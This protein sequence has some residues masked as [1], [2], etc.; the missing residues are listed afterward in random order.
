[1]P[2]PLALLLALAAAPPPCD[3]GAL[4]VLPL[5]AVAVARAE[6]L[7][8]EE[9][10]RRALAA[11]ACVQPAE[12]TRARL[13]ARD[14]EPLAAC[15][16]RACAPGALEALGA[17]W[18][19]RGTLLGVGGERTLALSLLGREGEAARRTVALGGLPGALEEGAR[20][21]WRTRRG[22]TVA[23]APSAWPLVT[24]A[25]GGVALAAGAGLGLAARQTEARLS[26]A[27]GCTG[28][29]E[30]VRA[31]L[32]AGLAEGR[33]QARAAN[34]LLGAGALLGAGGGLWLAWE[35]P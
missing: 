10:L 22:A 20:E 31:C 11:V 16:E 19:L 6:A 4:A 35:L 23:R 29:G 12:V 30:E 24:L 15:R 26:R 17:A 18:A 21:L 28:T 27:D 33:R 14:G 5:E 3:G 32:T 25:A 9:A 1:M 7:A 8:T 13:G 34:L 2:P